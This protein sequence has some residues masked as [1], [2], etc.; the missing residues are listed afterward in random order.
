VG[1][2]PAPVHIVS[3]NKEKKRCVLPWHIIDE[4]AG[5]E[6]VSNLP[7]VMEVFDR[8]FRPWP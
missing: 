3:Q 1:L 2:R 5:S 4:E 8:E 6:S 7:K